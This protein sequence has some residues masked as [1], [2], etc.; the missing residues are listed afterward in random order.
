VYAPLISC[1]L[2]QG[3]VRS[4][5][6][7]VTDVAKLVVLELEGSLSEDGF[8]VRLQMGEEGK[9]PDLDISGYL[10]SEPDLAELVQSHWIDKYRPLGLLN[11]R[12]LKP[13]AIKYD[14][15]ISRLKAC[16]ESGTQVCDRLNQWLCSPDFRD[17]DLQIR[18]ELNYSDPIRFILRTTCNDLQK[19]PWHSWNLFSRYK[20]AEISFSDPEFRRSD[21]LNSTPPGKVR[22][23]AI[24]GHREGIDTEKDCQI[25]NSLPHADVT[26]L[27]E[28]KRSEINDQLWEQPWDILFFAGHSETDG[29][30]GKIYINPD[31]YLTVD[32]IWFGLRKSVAQGLKLAIFNSCDGLG[33]ARRLD[34][35][36]IPQMIV[37]RDYVPDQVAQKFLK[38]FLLN[39]SQGYSFEVAVRQAREKLQGLEDQIPCATWL[40]VIWQHPDYISPT[41]D[42]LVGQPLPSSLSWQKALKITLCLSMA[43]TTLVMG[44]RSAGFLEPM[45]LRAFDQLMRSRP[46][47]QP[48]P[49]LLIVGVTEEDIELYDHPLPDRT[50]AEIIDKLDVHQPAAIGLNIYRDKPVPANSADQTMNQHFRQNEKLVSICKFEYNN[51]PNTSIDPPDHSPQKQVGFVNLWTD[52]HN[53]YASGMIRR[54]TLS[55]TDHMTPPFYHCKTPYSLAFQLAWKYLSSKGVVV[56]ANPQEDWQFGQKVFTSLKRGRPGYYQSDLPSEQILINYRSTPTREIAQRISADHVLNNKFKP[57]W[58]KDKIILIGMTAESVRDPQ[59]TPL[60][61]MRGLDI[62]AHVASQIISS[63]LDNRPLFWS[64][65]WWQDGLF[66][67]IWS[68]V[69]AITTLYFQKY[70]WRLGLGTALLCILV[71]Y[72]SFGIFLQGGLMALIPSILALLTTALCTRF[73]QYWRK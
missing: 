71:Y 26:F 20:S 68:M 73:Y 48:D 50:L 13:K 47:E 9:R 10:P 53:P 17:I 12:G 15:V 31:Q 70:P 43:V 54:Y 2:G 7:E 36:Q 60:G 62:H 14:G 49:R 39:F 1:N 38:S 63:V 57:S 72:L 29:E 61:L 59:H 4:D 6:P 19:L 16:E 40:P 35:V 41:W 11:T 46:V 51:D 45:E 69:G 22:I 67:W 44:V 65:T 24:L 27:I 28:P 5:S 37:M 64:L 23:L 32:Q 56:Q 52:Q 18:E 58:I 33:L 21:P 34:D 3:K 66:V 8:R 25:L 30:A 55:Q 42:D